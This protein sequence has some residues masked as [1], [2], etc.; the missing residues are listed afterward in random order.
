MKCCPRMSILLLLPANATLY[1]T[2][3]GY[4]YLFQHRNYTVLT[5]L[6]RC[7][8]ERE[9]E[10]VELLV[11][12]SQGKILYN[13]TWGAHDWGDANTVQLATCLRRVNCGN[14]SDRSKTHIHLTV[15]QI[16]PSTQ[17]FSTICTILYFTVLHKVGISHIASL[18]SSASSYSQFPPSHT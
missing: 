11:R 2:H 8:R 12:L 15:R 13:N 9:G 1:I 6:P 5:T 7:Q 16:K 10:R 17:D 14:K 3:P 18:A 4:T